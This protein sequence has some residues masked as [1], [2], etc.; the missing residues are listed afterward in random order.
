MEEIIKEKIVHFDEYCK[1]CVHW[2]EDDAGDTCNECLNNPSNE[3]S[4]KPVKF[5]SR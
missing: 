3:N 5:V 2:E 4:H 1:K